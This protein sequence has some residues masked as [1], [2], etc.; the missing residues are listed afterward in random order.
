MYKHSQRYSK[1][2][3]IFHTW[4]NLRY[5]KQICPYTTCVIQSK[6][7][8]LSHTWPKFFKAITNIINDTWLTLF[9]QLQIIMHIREVRYS[10]Q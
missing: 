1:Q 7:L 4:I 8:L 10:K 9:E 6:Q 2:L 5:L 3:Q